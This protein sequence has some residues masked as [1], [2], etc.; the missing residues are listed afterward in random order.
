MSLIETVSTLLKLLTSQPLHRRR[1]NDL[2]RVCLASAAF[3]FM[4]NLASQARSFELKGGFKT[5]DCEQVF[6]SSI[7]DV[8]YLILVFS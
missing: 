4:A 5:A 3:V 2:R 7:S 1:L 6:V 8:N